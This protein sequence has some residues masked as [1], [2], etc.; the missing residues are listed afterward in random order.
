MIKQSSKHLDL[1]TSLVEG[2]QLTGVQIKNFL[3]IKNP[4][5][6][7]HY[8]RTSGMKIQSVPVTTNAPLRKRFVQV[9]YVAE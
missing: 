3:G 5:R 4:R 8:L 6:A 7:V 9:R 2:A 1:A